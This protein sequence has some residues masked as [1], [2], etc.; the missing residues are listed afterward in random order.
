MQIT[1]GV[2]LSG[3]A[4]VICCA[5]V[6][7]SGVAAQVQAAGGVLPAPLFDIP[8]MDNI[9]IDGDAMD[10]GD[11]G[12]RVDVLAAADGAVAPEDRFNARMRLGWNDEGLLVLVQVRDEDFNESNDEKA[13]GS[14]N[15]VELFMV[16]K[17]GGSEMIQA[18]ISPGMDP[19]HPQ[20]R[21]SISDLRK[22]ETLKKFAPSLK[23]ARMKQE[24]GYSME[25]LLP[26]KNL[27]I[28]P[29]VGV[30]LAFQ[31]WLNG[32][33]AAAP[34]L[35][36]VWYPAAGTREAPDRTQ[37][38][39]LAVAP[40]PPVQA[41]GRARYD[42]WRSTHA[43]V[44]ACSEAAGK[45][46]SVLADGKE[47]A[48]GALTSDGSRSL[49]VLKAPLPPIGGEWKNLA[50]LLDGRT[51]D[52]VPMTDL[53]KARAGATAEL[54]FIFNPFS[55]NGKT[56]PG[57]DLENPLEAENII[58]PYTVK[59]TYY[60]AQFNPV[61]RADKPGRYGAIVQVTPA[62][63]PAFKR[64]YTLFR[65]AGNVQWN[66]GEG[67]GLAD[68]ISLSGAMG[69]DPVVVR[70]QQQFLADFAR[71]QT[72]DGFHRSE[73]GAI[74]LA[75][76]NEIGAGQV[77]TELTG[78]AASDERWKHELKRR[79]GNL[80]PLQYFVRMPRGA[81]HGEAKKCPAIIYLHGAGDRGWDVAELAFSPIVKY[82]G[83]RK[84]FPFIVIAPRCP[85]AGWWPNLVPEMEDLLDEII[86]KYPIDT[87]RIYLTGLS[88]GGYGSW[89]LAAEHPDRFAAL[90]PI[91]GGGDPRY[92]E[93]IKDL[94]I[95][96][97]HGA[98]DPTVSI[99]QSYE[100]VAALRKVHGRVHFTVYA[101]AGHNCWDRAYN[102]DEL[103]SWMLRQARGRPAEPQTT[104][105]GKTPS[106][107]LP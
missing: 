18:A 46:V 77:A 86:A 40:S 107:T 32:C 10:W 67:I 14:G 105:S 54:Q 79:T 52:T 44:V 48:R 80:T 94:P 11:G 13:L 2:L 58:G 102:T 90:V 64:F 42:G 12:F 17:C 95:W 75:W 63:S 38:I 96:D 104:L 100:M 98:K 33:D 36:A 28:K 1:H 39:R 57:G 72:T 97:F 99:E 30:E 37:R 41:A 101:E 49:A 66:W 21:Y 31:I 68:G 73:R 93:R 45:I 20:L 55:F 25:V 43:V 3:L 4:F 70:E 27:G 19:A 53:A 23:A 83:G 88:M 74:L 9:T 92:V 29:E 87:E 69:L 7:C 26:W 71:R 50:I 61:A 106:E 34:E 51:I 62:R 6:G 78:P 16:D 81:D 85:A 60:D 15:S 56:L 89:R 35:H 24:G 76:L 82:A 5:V 59:V 65:T 91:C 8:R 22:D 103:Y 84:D 47:I